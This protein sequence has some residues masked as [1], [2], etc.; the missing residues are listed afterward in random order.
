[1]SDPTPNILNLQLH[2]LGQIRDQLAENGS[3]LVRLENRLE[4]MSHRLDQLTKEKQ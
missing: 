3:R 2:A 4:S 1:M